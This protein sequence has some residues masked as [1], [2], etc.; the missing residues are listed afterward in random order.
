MGK[1]VQSIKGVIWDFEFVWK[2]TKASFWAVF[3]F[4]LVMLFL[5]LLFY[6]TI[7]VEIG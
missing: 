1:L 3:T 5:Y 7:L 2:A 4:V 6:N